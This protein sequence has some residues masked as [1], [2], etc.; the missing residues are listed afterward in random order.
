MFCV[1]CARYIEWLESRNFVPGVVDKK[2]ALQHVCDLQPLSNDADEKSSPLGRSN[3]PRYDVQNGGVSSKAPTL[4]MDSAMYDVEI[5]DSHLPATEDGP[6]GRATLTRKA[7]RKGDVVCY[8]WGDYLYKDCSKYRK[9]QHAKCDRFMTLTN[10]EIMKSF[11]LLGHQNCAATFIQ[12]AQ[13]TGDQQDEIQANVQFFEQ[14]LKDMC[15]L[16]PHKYVQVVALRDIEEGEVL[17][18]NYTLGAATKKRKKEKPGL[19]KKK[20]TRRKSSKSKGAKRPLSKKARK[21]PRPKKKRLM[22]DPTS[23]EDDH[24]DFSE[25][26]S[27]EPPNNGIHTSSS[28][29]SKY[30]YKRVRFKKK[31]DIFTEMVPG[32]PLPAVGEFTKPPS[33]RFMRTEAGR[34]VDEILWFL[35]L[36]IAYLHIHM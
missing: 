18:A 17:Y 24:S 31:V 34:K 21:Q 27:D 8:Y 16:N 14:Q 33:Y 15:P 20:D 7:V 35:L 1:L 36:L 5:V 9:L 13:Y 29:S 2:I 30:R 10:L 4:A 25:P 22:L 11:V 26:Q 12:S 28:N 3:Y 32:T 6:A 19:Q 23:T